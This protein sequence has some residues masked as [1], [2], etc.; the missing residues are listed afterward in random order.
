MEVVT[1]KKSII[2][3]F[4]I[5]V[6]LSIFTLYTFAEGTATTYRD[7]Y[8]QI[9]FTIPEG[10]SRLE[11]VETGQIKYAF[12]KDASENG[13]CFVYSYLDLYSNINDEEKIEVNRKE[14]NNSTVSVEEFRDLMKSELSED[15]GI[16]N[17]SVNPVTVDGKSF[18]KLVFNQSYDNNETEN[19]VVYCHIYD[20][21]ATYY[22]YETFDSSL[23]EALDEAEAESIVRTVVFENE[24]GSNKTKTKSQKTFEAAGKSVLKRSIEGGIIGLIVTT[25]GVFK[26]VSI[27]KNKKKNSQV[28]EYQNSNDSAFPTTVP[29]EMNSQNSESVPTNDSNNDN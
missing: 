3:L 6:F 15:K 11:E 10:W 12:L 17:L 14:I 8:L 25:A 1:M 21:Y 22:R 19:V 2:S 7:D 26:G 13:T 28:T 23:D 9:S 24:K 4:L 18:F 27:K 16:T 29:T 5:T 20:G